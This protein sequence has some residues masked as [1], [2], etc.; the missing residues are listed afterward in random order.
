MFEPS[1]RPSTLTAGD[2]R[3]LLAM[4]PWRSDERRIIVRGLFGRAAI[5]IEPAI[6]AVLFSA[7]GLRLLR[8]GTDGNPDHG[9]LQL[10]A[11]I[12][13]LGAA[14]FAVYAILLLAAPFRAL[15]ETFQPIFVVDGYVR[16]RGRDDFS[17]RGFNGYVA[18]LLHDHRVACEWPTVGVGDLPNRTDAAHMEFSE[19]GGIHT[20]DGRPTGV[21]PAAFS[22][23]GVRSNE[24]P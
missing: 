20:I 17:Q 14:M 18:V 12:F 21:L 22:N 1:V 3:Q 5:A 19:Y 6:V 7:F 10:L 9:G 13:L 8:L 4:R 24:P 2:R 23:I 11:P 16:T 15:R